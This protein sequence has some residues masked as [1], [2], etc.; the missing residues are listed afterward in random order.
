MSDS[1][2]RQFTRTLLKSRQ[3]TRTLLNILADLNDFLVWMVSTCPLI[4]KSSGPSMLGG[5]FQVHHLQL[6]S[7][8]PSCYIV[9]FCSQT[10][11]RY[12][13]IYLFAF[14]Y[15]TLRSG[16]MAKSTNRQVLFV[17]LTTTRSGRL[18]VLLLLLLFTH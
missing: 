10:R 12:L 14:F 5:L 4:S 3:F 15:F 7:P 18:A 8:T 2:S 13:F 16:G 1:K 9:F 6:V 11:S 17:L